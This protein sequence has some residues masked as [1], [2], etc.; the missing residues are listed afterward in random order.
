VCVDTFEPTAK[1]T[2]AASTSPIITDTTEH[3]DTE[4]GDDELGDDATELSGS[5]ENGAEDD[6]L[7]KE[8]TKAATG[9]RPT[10]NGLPD[11]IDCTGDI[12]MCDSEFLGEVFRSS[13]PAMCSTCKPTPTPTEPPTHTTLPTPTTPRPTTESLII[14]TPRLLSTDPARTTTTNVATTSTTATTKLKPHVPFACGP[15][16]LFCAAQNKVFCAQ[17]VFSEVCLNLCNSCTSTTTT[18]T[19]RVFR[20]EVTLEDAIGSHACSV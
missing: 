8:T 18:R 19:V 11:P 10:C 17:A 9:V 4:L 20:Q 13:C 16:P 5:G 15:D 3:G 12:S 2:P 1:P 6:L 14:T 7:G